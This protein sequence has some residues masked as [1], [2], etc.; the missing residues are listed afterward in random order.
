VN[1][2]FSFV[3]S[4]ATAAPTPILP[5]EENQERKHHWTGDP[6]KPNEHSAL[7]HSNRIEDV[8][9]FFQDMPWFGVLDA[10]TQ[11]LVAAALA[12]NASGMEGFDLQCFLMFLCLIRS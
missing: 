5:R 12:V 11:P 9:F 7:N 4:F 2:A 10:S 1:T 8:N 6:K 3:F